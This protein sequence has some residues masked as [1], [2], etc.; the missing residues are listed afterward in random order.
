[1]WEWSWAEGG[2]ERR[3]GEKFE[4]ESWDEVRCGENGRRERK[5][6]RSDRGGEKW[7]Q[8]GEEGGWGGGR[9]EC[10]RAVSRGWLGSGLGEVFSEAEAPSGLAGSTLLP[11]C[12]GVLSIPEAWGLWA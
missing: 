9:V 2:Y 3:W 4:E 10:G 5:G 1:M 6:R 8:M 11:C 12:L 7:D